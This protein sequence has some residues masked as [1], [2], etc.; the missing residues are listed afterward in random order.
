M[1]LKDIKISNFRNYDNLS[2][3]FEKG[4]NIIYGNNGQGKTNLLESLY[5]LGMTKSHRSYIDNNLIKLNQKSLYRRTALGCQLYIQENV[6]EPDKWQFG[7]SFLNNFVTLF[8]Y[9]NSTITFY[10][11]EAFKQLDLKPHTTL[12]KYYIFIIM[13]LC[14]LMLFFIIKIKTNFNIKEDISKRESRIY[15]I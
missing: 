1:Y 6:E 11:N 2:I 5:V 10:T 12:K 14:I 4:I 15:L 13:L 7:M 8:N 9:E 3:S